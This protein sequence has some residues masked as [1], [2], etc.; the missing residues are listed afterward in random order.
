MAAPAKKNQFALT[1]DS[2]DRIKNNQETIKDVRSKLESLKKLGMDM[3]EIEDKLNWAEEAGNTIIKD[4][5][6]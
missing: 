4:F 2:I 6:P 1:Q 3:R 5:A